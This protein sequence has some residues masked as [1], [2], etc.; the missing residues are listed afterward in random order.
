MFGRWQDPTQYSLVRP[1]IEGIA[2]VGW[3]VSGILISLISLTPLLPSG[4][5]VWTAAGALALGFVR[6][7]QYLRLQWAKAGMLTYPLEVLGPD[8][9]R[10]SARESSDT[11]L[12]YGFRWDAKCRQIAYTIYNQ[13]VENIKIPKVVIGLYS[14]VTKRPTKGSGAAW[15]QGIGKEDDVLFTAKQSEGHTM[16]FG[17]PGSGKTRMADLLVTQSISRGDITIAID[18]K[19]DK[20][21]EQRM[22][23]EAKEAGR[24]YVYFHLAKPEDSVRWQPIAQWNRPTEI[25]SRLAALIP[26]ETGSDAFTAFSW[27]TL[28]SAA[29][30]SVLIL[31]EQP[32]LADLK[33]T[34]QWQPE[35]LTIRVLQRWLG[36]H[37]PGWEAQVDALDAIGG[38]AKRSKQSPFEKLI[39]YYKRHGPQHSAIDGLISMATHNRDH[40]GKMIATLLPLLEMLTAGHLRALLSPDPVL[41]ADDPRPVWDM[42]RVLQ[43]NAVCYIGLDTLSDATVGSS[44]G[45]LFIAELAS[46]AGYAYNFLPK[47]QMP[48]VTLVVDE[49]S[50]VLNVPLV[51]MANKA[52]GAR[53]EIFALAQTF[54]EFA[55]KMGSEA[56]GRMFAGNFN[57]LLV[58]RTRDRGT[59]EYCMEQFG[60]GLVSV[61]SRTQGTDALSFNDEDAA[62]GS[63]VSEQLKQQEA[64]VFPASLLG[65]LPTFHYIA[66]LGG[67]LVKGRIPVLDS[68]PQSPSS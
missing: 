50:E 47:E 18:P 7:A 30:G 62:F 63:K 56:A 52:R 60:K 38:D 45:S 10:H 32:T 68:M 26:S 5:I 6:T 20:D 54:S 27:M 66:A 24:P 51:Q 14:A 3:L 21:L 46:V 57:N 28:A 11:W 58:L 35:E 4:I 43:Q 17:V 16:V 25:P 64:E 39:A 41:D 15:L 12:G 48:R 36:K 19:G 61:M 23:Q 67:E 29:L 59:Q 44:V 42:R 31:H 49:S 65:S 33:E 8:K 34:V 53:F 40:Y 22:R 2:A 9:L 37:R 1:P 55:A 13:G